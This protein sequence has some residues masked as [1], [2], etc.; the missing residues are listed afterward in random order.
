MI[1]AKQFEATAQYY[2]SVLIR[3]AIG[4]LGN[5]EDAEDSVQRGLMLAWERRN[6]FQERNGAALSTWIFTV[7]SNAARDLTRKRAA[8]RHWDHVN[9]TEAEMADPRPAVSLEQSS[10]DRFR[11]RMIK[12]CP[13][14]SRGERELIRTILEGQEPP[15]AKHVMKFRAIK[16]LRDYVSPS[17]ASIGRTK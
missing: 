14:L 12:R 8:R 16:K 10:V 6:Q 1:T 9:I 11:V 17:A 2:R 13:T 5:A 4:I 7:V 15:R 3:N